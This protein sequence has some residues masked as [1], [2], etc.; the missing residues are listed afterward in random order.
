M[1]GA[2][3]RTHGQARPPASMQQAFVTLPAG[4]VRVD[5]NVTM[6]CDAHDLRRTP[7]GARPIH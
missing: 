1:D 7:D 4:G 3:R 2:D 5:A 6:S